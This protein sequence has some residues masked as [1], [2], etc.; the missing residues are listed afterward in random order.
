MSENTERDAH[1]LG[2]AKLLLDEI[3]N[4]NDVWFD[5]AD[6]HFREDWQKIIAQCVYDL[7]EHARLHCVA[8]ALELDLDWI[9]AV[10]SAGRMP[11]LTEWPEH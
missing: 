1:F 3:M 7:V 5:T 10:D 2:F 4:S 11:D 9:T 8:R 6:A